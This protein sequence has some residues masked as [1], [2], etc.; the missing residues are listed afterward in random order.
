MSVTN[1][2]QGPIP[3]T[4]A[5]RPTIAARN[6][7]VQITVRHRR[8]AT[9]RGSRI[10]V[11]YLPTAETA[12]ANPPR[13]PS[14]PTRFTSAAPTSTPMIADTLLTRS[15]WKVLGDSAT[16]ST[17]TPCA[18]VSRPRICCSTHPACSATTHAHKQDTTTQAR[19][20]FG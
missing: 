4:I 12:M 18:R 14:R 13:G 1:V 10:A 2:C 20:A 7:H 9:S 5:D 15:D 11:A 16:S 19:C 6:T 8:M 17:S 3:V